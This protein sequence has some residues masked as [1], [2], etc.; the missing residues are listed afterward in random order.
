MAGAP[1]PAADTRV[2]LRAV[3]SI[4]RLIS[5]SDDDRFLK[6]VLT[7]AAFV[8]RYTPEQESKNNFFVTERPPKYLH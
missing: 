7:S 4:D 6:E 2:A 8:L 5:E 3:A 1:A